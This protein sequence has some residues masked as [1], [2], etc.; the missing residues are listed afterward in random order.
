MKK[1]QLHIKTKYF[2]FFLHK[3]QLFQQQY[4]DNT[5]LCAKIQ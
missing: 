1:K 5:Y 2:L 4:G 3:N